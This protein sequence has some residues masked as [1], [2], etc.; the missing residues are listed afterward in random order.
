MAWLKIVGLPLRL[1][2]EANFTTICSRFGKVSCPF[3]CVSTRRDLSMGKVGILTSAR[4]WINEKVQIM[5]GGQFHKVGVV[6]YTND[7]CPFTPCPFDKTVDYNGDEESD[8]VSDAWMNDAMLQ[9]IGNE[10]IEFRVYDD[11][12]GNINF[13]TSEVP[14]EPKKSATNTLGDQREEEVES[15]ALGR[16]DTWKVSMEEDTVDLSL[17]A[18]KENEL[19]D[20]QLPISNFEGPDPVK[21][22]ILPDH[23]DVVPANEPFREESLDLNNNPLPSCS[24][25]GDCSNPVDC[26]SYSNEIKATVELGLKLGFKSSLTTRFLLIN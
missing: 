13:G 12:G 5:A 16:G 4:R 17:N 14:A 9:K 1:W 11:G 6:E 24:S 8:R 26:S 21:N 22:P 2:D 20:T 7:W 23:D 10:E 19:G 15:D 18:G 25:C 3:D